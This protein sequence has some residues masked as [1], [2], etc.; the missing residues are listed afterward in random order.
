MSLYKPGT[1]KLFEALRFVKILYNDVAMIA[2][3]E[4]TSNLEA[5]RIRKKRS[6]FLNPD[7]ASF[8]LFLPWQ[9]SSTESY[10]FS[11]FCG[12]KNHRQP[13]QKMQ[14]PKRKHKFLYALS[15][16]DGSRTLFHSQLLSRFYKLGTTKQGNPVIAKMRYRNLASGFLFRE[17]K[18]EK[19]RKQCS[20]QAIF[21]LLP[22]LLL[23]VHSF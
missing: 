14:G 19:Q 4:Q 10:S 1:G 11:E 21:P 22:P 6:A 20:G 15:M 2:C 9:N 5:T 3:D 17:K 23:W 13:F 7:R 18:G 12:E 8:V 16:Q